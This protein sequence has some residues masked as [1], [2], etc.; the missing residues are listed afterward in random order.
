MPVAVD[1]DVAD[2]LERFIGQGVVLARNRIEMRVAGEP[3]FERAI[4]IGPTDAR[5]LVVKFDRNAASLDDG[6]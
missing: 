2:R 6:T 3:R 4:E 1:R 5:E